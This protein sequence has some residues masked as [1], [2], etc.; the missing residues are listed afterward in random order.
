MRILIDR[1]IPFLEGVLDSVAEVEFLPPDAFTPERVRQADALIVR[2]R[3]RCDETLLSG[4][5]VQFIA[6]ATIGFDHIDTAYCAEHGIVWTACPGCNAQAV[7]DYVEEVLCESEHRLSACH[8]IGIVGV[9]HVGSLVAQMA[10]QRG[11]DVVLNDPPKGLYGDVSDCDVVTFHTPLTYACVGEAYPT[12]HLCDQTFLKR[13]PAHTLIVNAARGGVVD[14][15]ALLASGH[16]CVIDCWEGEPQLNRM[17]LSSPN[18]WLASYHIAGYSLQG[19]W[20]ASAMCVQALCAHFH[21]PS[22]ELDPALVSE[23]KHGDS[24]PGWL[25]RVTEQLRREPT[26]FEALR[27]A[28]ALR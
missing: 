17:L 23:H 11:M 22:I 4:S 12:Y 25:S 15:A 8:K 6:T 7:C 16:P 26:C 9:G 14:E 24:S 10:Q 13:L 3:T 1:Y 18:T 21:L 2:T 28:Y 20:N 27:K 19:K 5:R